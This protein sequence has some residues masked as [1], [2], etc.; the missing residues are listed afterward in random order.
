MKRPPRIGM[1]TTRIERNVPGGDW[2][3]RPNTYDEAVVAAGGI[4]VSIP[5]F[6]PDELLDHYLDMLDG[7]LFIGG[8]DLPGECYGRE[9]FPGSKTLDLYVAQNH[10]TLVK[11]VFSRD[12][13]VLGICLGMQEF[14][15]AFGGKLIPDLGE[16]TPRHRKEGEAQYHDGIIE[17]D[18]KSV[19]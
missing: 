11:K 19:V 13:P 9:D 5:A 17:P 3:V 15:V 18:R 10:L 6:V 8:A 14:N 2:Y 12:L 4:P 1:T 7:F 16:K